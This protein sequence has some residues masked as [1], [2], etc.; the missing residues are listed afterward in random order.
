MPTLIQTLLG[1]NRR[2]QRRSHEIRRRYA[3]IM[4]DSGG[5]RRRAMIWGHSSA[6]IQDHDKVAVEDHGEAAIQDRK[7]I[8]I[9]DRD[10]ITIAG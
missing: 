10:K 4:A 8:A 2:D 9:E 7:V 3:R 1:P 6:V 5:G